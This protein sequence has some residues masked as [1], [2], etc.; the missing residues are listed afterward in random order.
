MPGPS[1]VATSPRARTRPARRTGPRAGC[2]SPRAGGAVGAGARHGIRHQLGT[3]AVAL[4]VGVDEQVLELAH[5]AVTEH[6]GE[7]DDPAV[8]GRPAG[9]APRA[10]RCRAAP[11]PR[12]G[13]AALG[14]AR[15]PSEARRKTSRS[16]GRSPAPAVRSCTTRPVS[17]SRRPGC[18]RR[19][20]P[21]SARSGG[22][23]ASAPTSAVRGRR[24]LPPRCPRRRRARVVGGVGRGDRPGGVVVLGPTAHELVGV[25]GVGP[26][27]EVGR[28]RVAAACCGGWRRVG[29]VGGEVLDGQG[30]GAGAVV[31]RRARR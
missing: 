12:G 25:G 16:T 31:T 3:D 5:R 19:C 26:L 17:R 24:R 11:A 8:V 28:D 9:C 27:L 23:C 15:V 2:R 1:S 6:R 14:V 30:I 10:P 20:R 13:R 7:P 22:P 29:D 21:S 4:R 18:R